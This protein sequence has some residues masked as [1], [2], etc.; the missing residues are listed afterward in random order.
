MECSFGISASFVLP[1][2]QKILALCPKVRKVLFRP[3]FRPKGCSTG[4][5]QCLT[6][7]PGVFFQIKFS[8]EKPSKDIKLY[9]TPNKILPKSSSGH[10]DF[11]LDTLVEN[12]C[13]KSGIYSLKIRKE[14]QTYIFLGKKPVCLKN[15]LWTFGMRC[16]QLRQKC[17]TKKPA[18]S[19]SLPKS[20]KS[21]GFCQN[22][23]PEVLRSAGHVESLPGS[24][25]FLFKF[26][27]NQRLRTRN[28]WRIFFLRTLKF[29][30]KVHEMY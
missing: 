19:R 13:N 9:L 10:V 8:S 1:E 5:V 23:F 15:F 17:F 16:W 21:F 18:T 11:V 24:S 22:Y 7:E 14:C 12:F 20:Q 29:F 2:T 6:D 30:A 25:S 27:R 3:E 26:L 4:R 28:R